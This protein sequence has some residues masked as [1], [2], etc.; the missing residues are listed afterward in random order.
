VPKRDLVGVVSVRLQNRTLRFSAELPF[1]PILKRELLNFRVRL[2]P[3]TSHDSY[4]AWREGD[5]DELVLATAVALWWGDR[6]PRANHDGPY[7]IM[8]ASM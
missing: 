2:D 5:H 7:Q 6:Q 4:S 1:A 3:V 8:K